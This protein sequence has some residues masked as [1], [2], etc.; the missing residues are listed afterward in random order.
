MTDVLVAVTRF[1]SIGKI[2][3]AVQQ[4][5]GTILERDT[6]YSA[7]T[8]LPRETNPD[9]DNIVTFTSNGGK[10]VVDDHVTPPVPNMKVNDHQFTPPELR[11]SVQ[12]QP[13]KIPE[14]PLSSPSLV[15][16]SRTSPGTI[17]DRQF[18][19][20]LAVMGKIT[21]AEAISYVSTGA[22]PASMEV[23]INQLPVDQQFTA[24]M[25][26][27]GETMFHRNNP[28]VK[29][30]GTAYGFTSADLDALWAAA[31]LL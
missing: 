26:I 15:P 27:I 28:L 25:Q 30:L 5:D 1:T 7:L 19:Q 21:S 6:V 24:R 13:V 17:T 9:Y 10:I 22:I 2:R 16:I 3:V 31:I 23:L 8:G 4:P 29:E 18:F 20:Q 14:A 11:P 12:V